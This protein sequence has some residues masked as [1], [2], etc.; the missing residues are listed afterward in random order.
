AKGMYAESLALSE[1]A[2]QP[3]YT[4]YA[5]M[6]YS[7]A[8]LGRRPE[9]NEILTKYKENEKTKY[10]MNYWIGVTYAALG[11]KDAAFAE[12]EKAYRNHDWFLQRLKV[13]PFIDNL[14]DDPR[15][16]DLLKRLNLPE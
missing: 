11:E 3:D 2:S 16:K 9:A 14:R 1:K 8:K 7:Y 12:F 4:F 10:V 15:Y 13:D 5:Q 6:G